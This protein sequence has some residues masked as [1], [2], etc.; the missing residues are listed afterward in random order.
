M[1]YEDT[2][3]K[4]AAL[5]DQCRIQYGRQIRRGSQVRNGSPRRFDYQYDLLQETLDYI[6]Y[7]KSQI[8]S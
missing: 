2:E 5:R 4:L 6:A 8:P 7:L 1:A 3:A